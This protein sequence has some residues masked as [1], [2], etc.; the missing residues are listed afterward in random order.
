MQFPP[1]AT[2]QILLSLLR[3]AAS[4]HLPA[5]ARHIHAHLLKSCLL[6]S[7]PFP[8]SLLNAYTKSDLQLDAYILFDE[9]PHPDIFL[10]SSILA[11]HARYNSLSSFLSIFRRM[12]SVHFLLPDDFVLATLVNAC[13]RFLSLRLG[14]QVHAYVLVSTFSSDD[15][16][17]SSLVDMYSKC[18]LPNDARRVFDSIELKNFVSLTTMVS[19]YAANGCIAEALELFWRMRERS[20]FVWTA[21]ISGLVR[22]GN[23]FEGLNL[24]V[25]MRREGTRIDDAFVLSSVVSASADMAMLALGKQLHC[26][27]VSLGY[28][29]NMM[30]GNAFV[31]MYAKCSDIASSRMAFDKILKIKCVVSWTTMIVGEAQ[32][33]RAEESLD[34]FARMVS[35]GVKPNEITF[36]GLI[37]A[38]SHIGLVWKGRELFD[39]M[40]KDYGI[41]PSLKHYTCLLDLFSR[42]GHLSEA[43]SLIQIMPYEPD[44]AAW[45]ALLSACNKHGDIQLGVHVADKLLR[46]KPQV[47]S[48]YILLS[49]TYAIA[50]KW[51][52]VANARK[53]MD[54]L[55]IKKQPGYSWIEVGRESCLFQAGVVP[56][57]MRENILALLKELMEEMK[58]R[59]YVPDTSSVLH[60]L[61]EDEKELQLFMHSERLAVAFG[62]LKSASGMTIRVLKNLR[63]CGDCHTFMKLISSISGREIVVRDANRF[64]HFECGRCSCGDFW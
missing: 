10:Y 16:V 22:S 41:K 57:H 44:E 14:R 9:I 29:S 58:K 33:G 30:L 2:A 12:I 53:L 39:S 24:F 4:F 1:P 27:S 59:G 45:A 60:D 49:N 51:D 23:G 64:H 35:S 37:Y 26:L 52:S 21:L 50:G 11:A 56:L 5:V 28:E 15:I 6:H 47:S 63:V 46:L 36:V 19:G 32:H 61:D 43:Q 17:K 8:S 62:L 42:S 48:T 7:S 40:L 38:C 13:A 55:E 34:L 54:D 20:V 18:G 25:E 3:S 31:D